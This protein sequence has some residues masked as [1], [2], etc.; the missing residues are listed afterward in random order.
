MLTGSFFSAQ[1]SLELFPNCFCQLL[2]LHPEIS[3]D[4][5]QIFCLNYATKPRFEWVESSGLVHTPDPL[6]VCLSALSLPREIPHIFKDL[7][8]S[9]LLP[10]SKLL[11]PA[12]LL[13][14][15]HPARFRSSIAHTTF[16]LPSVFPKVK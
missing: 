8:R 9:H 14:E 7:I 10:P 2:A 11:A 12:V 4:H 3:I 16:I 5:H 13:A 15:G 1:K 6:L